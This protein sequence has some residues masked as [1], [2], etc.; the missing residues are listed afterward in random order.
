MLRARF[1]DALKEAMRAKH[2]RKVGTVR[3][4]I[5]A[6]KDRD[7]AARGKGNAD[8]I[9]DDEI[10]QM[11]Q[12]MIKSRRE[13]IVLY[14]QGGRVELAEQEREEI[15]IIATFLPQQMSAAEVEAA[16]KA[17]IAEAGAKSIKDMGKVMATLK[18]R[19]VGQMDFAKAS[20][21]IK[22]SLS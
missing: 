13:S 14:E 10:A 7:I 12:S 5:A 16:I 8:G 4:I 17:A 22:A 1:S 6:L 19:H 18:A 20:A 15:A 21:A 2:E 11:L 3:L 9:G